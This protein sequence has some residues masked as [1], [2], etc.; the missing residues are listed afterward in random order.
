MEPN[1]ANEDDDLLMWKP[2]VIE[3]TIPGTTKTVY[4]RYP[5]FEDWHA[6]ATEH[7]AY[8]GKPAP[9]SLVAK[10]LVACVVKK[11]GEPMFTRENVGPVMQAN[12]NHVMWLYGHILQTVMKNDNE[13]ISEVE[14]NS[15]AGQD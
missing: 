1:V 14:K 7:Q 12:P 5:V 10:T 8:V 6:V 13:Q 15:V 9:A 3:A 4:L 11:S 2:E